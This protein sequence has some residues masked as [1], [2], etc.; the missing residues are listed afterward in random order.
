MH[1]WDDNEKV[2]SVSRIAWA[3]II[4]MMRCFAPLRL[5]RAFCMVATVVAAVLTLAACSPPP[6]P[7]LAA[8]QTWTIETH[9]GDGAISVTT[10]AIEASTPVGPVAFVMVN[11]MI[12][13]MP[14]KT[15]RNKLGPIAITL[16]ALQASLKNYEFKQG[17]NIG[18]DGFM[19]RWKQLASQGRA[20]EFTYNIP[21]AKALDEFER[22]NLK[23]WSLAN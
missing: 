6:P 22:G 11:N 15:K 5:A 16:P 14:D 8:G 20:A 3:K 10:L 4:R 21:V 13:T 1:G 18:V 19:G 7:A 23:P 2:A 12:I 9:R 17:M